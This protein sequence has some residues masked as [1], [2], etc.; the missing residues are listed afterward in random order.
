MEQPDFIYFP[1]ASES[2]TPYPVYKTR[3]GFHH[4]LYTEVAHTY[5]EAQARR[6][7]GRENSRLKPYTPVLWAAC[8]KFIEWRKAQ[9]AAILTAYHNLPNQ[10]NLFK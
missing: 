1:P 2:M 8:E 10:M 4:N 7:T 9:Q 3:G 5:E 6:G